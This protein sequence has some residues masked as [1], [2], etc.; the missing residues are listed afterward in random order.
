MTQLRSR[1][2]TGAAA[3]KELLSRIK[4][5]DHLAHSQPQSIS[6]ILRKSRGGFMRH[7]FRSTDK[8]S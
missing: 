7:R 2:A 5:E 8:K 3:P 4:T 1:P 6:E